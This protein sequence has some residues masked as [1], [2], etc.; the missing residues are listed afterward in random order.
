MLDLVIKG[1]R[2]VTPTGVGEW[3]IAVQGERIDGVM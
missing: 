3:D 2:V 1:G